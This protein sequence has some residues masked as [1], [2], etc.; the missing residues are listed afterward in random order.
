MDNT[1]LFYTSDPFKPISIKDSSP[2]DSEDSL[3]RS[4]VEFYVFITEAAH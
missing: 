3:L 1:A 4:A 2:N